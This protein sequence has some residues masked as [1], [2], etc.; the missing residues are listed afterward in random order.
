M[1]TLKIMLLVAIA[2]LAIACNN[3]KDAAISGIYVVDSKNEYTILS[4]TLIISAY[5]LS[6]GVYEVEKRSGYQLIRSGKILPKE[7]KRKSWKAT[8]DKNEQVLS[9]TALGRQI[10]VNAAAGTVSFGATY[11]KIN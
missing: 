6:A 10:Y 11:R 8:F 2:L 3:R 1:K 7:F 4:D 5:N 9:E